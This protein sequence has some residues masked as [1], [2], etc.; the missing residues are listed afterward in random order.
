MLLGLLALGKLG[1]AIYDWHVD[2]KE[3]KESRREERQE[4]VRASKKKRRGLGSSP[5]E[6][7]RRLA[8]AAAKSKRY[9]N[10]AERE[11]IKGKCDA[12]FERHELA[13]AKAGA[14]KAE[15][16]NVT[17]SNDHLTSEVGQAL[18]DSR[19]AIRACYAK[20]RGW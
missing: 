10:E 8:E 12:A 18:D 2:R 7:G 9:A 6:H 3:E 15:I 19:R 16:A 13:T 17:T 11:A 20:Q 5:D 14:V 4:R 1:L